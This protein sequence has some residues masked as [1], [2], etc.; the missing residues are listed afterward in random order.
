MVWIVSYLYTLENKMGLGKVFFFG[1]M[2]RRMDEC[3]GLEARGLRLEAKKKTKTKNQSR[4]IPQFFFLF[5]FF[6]F[7]PPRLPGYLIPF[8]PTT[9]PTRKKSRDRMGLDTPVVCF[10]FCFFV[11]FSFLF[12]LSLHA[13]R[14]RGVLRTRQHIS[15]DGQ[16]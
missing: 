9:F 1:Q 14:I 10:L 8:D 6:F 15:L 4:S 5:S 12:S 16:C 7:F 11:F 3:W 2:D 13:K